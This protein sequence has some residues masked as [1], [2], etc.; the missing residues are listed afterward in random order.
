ME[1]N[2]VKYRK[3]Y[4]LKIQNNVKLDGRYLKM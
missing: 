1:I 3:K 2:G 4:Q